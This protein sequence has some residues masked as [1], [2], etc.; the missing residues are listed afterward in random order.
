MTSSQRVTQLQP[1]YMA[2]VHF[3]EIICCNTEITFVVCVFDLVYVSFKK[4]IT[5]CYYL[6][7]LRY[8]PIFKHNQDVHNFCSKTMKRQPCWC[9]NK[10][11]WELNSFLM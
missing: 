8:I 10:I 11:L 6:S 2:V 7:L 4:G 1:V 5:A 9:T 3:T